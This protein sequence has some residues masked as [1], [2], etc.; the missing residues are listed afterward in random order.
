MVRR[1][2][3][4]QSKRLKAQAVMHI[5][6][7]NSRI[8]PSSKDLPAGRSSSPSRD[9]SRLGLGH[10]AGHEAGCALAGV[11]PGA[12]GLAGGVRKRTLG[13]AW[14][15]VAGVRGGEAERTVGVG[16]D[17]LAA[18]DEDVLWG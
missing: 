1:N 3:H 8:H 6:S 14:R 5:P 11:G 4:P 12:E 16:V 7:R 13:G 18:G 9:S 2:I 17:G 10:G 15:H